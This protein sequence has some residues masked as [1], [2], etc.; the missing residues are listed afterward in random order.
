MSTL[1]LGELQPGYGDMIDKNMIPLLLNFRNGYRA[2]KAGL[3]SAGK[4]LMNSAIYEKWADAR[5][6][7][8]DMYALQS[9]DR[10]KERRGMVAECQRGCAM[11][12]HQ[13]VVV[14]TSEAVRL[15]IHVAEK[16]IDVSRVADAARLF[17]GMTVSQRYSGH[18]PC[19]LLADNMCSV[20]TARPQP[21][22]TYFSFSVASCRYGWENPDDTESTT[23]LAAEAQGLGAMIIMGSDAALE[24]FGLQIAHLELADALDQA[25]KPGVVDRWVRGHRVFKRAANDRYG[26]VLANLRKASR[27]L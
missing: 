25:L 13:H 3:P 24:D 6:Q 18:H 15:A 22:R 21:C 12:C 8:I 26:E 9:L 23:T 1:P 2:G 20:Y 11:C 7:V 5:Y 27:Q 17:D 10:I 16:G 14:S 4:H 19:P